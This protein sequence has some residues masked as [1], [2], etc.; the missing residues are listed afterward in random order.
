VSRSFLRRFATTAAAV[1]IAAGVLLTNPVPADAGSTAKLATTRPNF[2]PNYF[3]ISAGADLTQEGPQ[4]FDN[5]MNLMHVAGTHW[6][7]A[8]IPWSQVQHDQDGEENWLMV[9]RLVNMVLADGMELDAIIDGPP[10]WAYD[11]PPPVAN[12]VDTPSFDVS[13]YAA[14]AAEVA[15][16]YGSARI[17]VIELENAPN[18]PGATNAWK[19]VN[20]CAYTR[21]MQ[22]SYTA[23]K[24]VDPAITVLTG[25]LGAQNNPHGGIAGETYFKQMYSFGVQGSFDAVSWH[26]YSYPC[27]PS[28]SCPKARP[29]YR[30]D[31]VRQAMVDNGDAGKLIW[32]TEFGAPTDGSATDGHVDENNQAAM[33]VNAM[34][35]WMTFSFAGPLFIFEFRD[36]GGSTQQKSN[37]FGLIS[38]D[39]K[40]RKLSYYTFKYEA[41]GHTKVTIPANVLAGQ[42]HS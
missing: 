42:P 5:E 6:V 31:V 20:A 24:A 19:T 7:R 41:T 30:T 33:M 15:Q 39:S 4:L 16:R 10:L 21:L 28:M 40:H 11:N 27:F 9:D 2:P 1:S 29:W 13:A 37:W 14:F 23:I 17:P 35:N 3:G 34:K 38:H 36:T 25:G 22:Q 12:C 8:V 26:P 18:L 32:A